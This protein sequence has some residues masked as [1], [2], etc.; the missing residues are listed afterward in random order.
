MFW[1]ELELMDRTK[2]E[3][4]VMF[5]SLFKIKRGVIRNVKHAKVDKILKE[6][7]RGADVRVSV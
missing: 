4:C 7:Q 3:E 2:I 6:K 1:I 5:V